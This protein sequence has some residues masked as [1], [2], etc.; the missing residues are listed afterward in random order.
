MNLGAVRV[1]RKVRSNV[2][3][4]NRSIVPVSFQLQLARTNDQLS[5][6]DIKIHPTAINGLQPGSVRE[7]QVSF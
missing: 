2:A 7:V 5:E 4:V 3:I 6:E 1:G